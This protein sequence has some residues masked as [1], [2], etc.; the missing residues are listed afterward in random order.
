MALQQLV[1]GLQEMGAGLQRFVAL[2]EAQRDIKQTAQV[3]AG[4]F[5]TGIYAMTPGENSSRYS[6]HLPGLTRGEKIYFGAVSAG[7][8]AFFAGGVARSYMKHGRNE[9]NI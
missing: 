9:Q 5:A 4:I 7:S 8:L 6:E 1:S 2:P 3:A